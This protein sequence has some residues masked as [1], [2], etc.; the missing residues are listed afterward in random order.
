MVILQG[1]PDC[2]HDYVLQ[3]VNALE[4]KGEKPVTIDREEYDMNLKMEKRKK[5]QEAKRLLAEE[6][7]RL[8]SLKK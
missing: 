5:D 8:R 6:N 2:L 1:K 4:T 7:K 3:Y